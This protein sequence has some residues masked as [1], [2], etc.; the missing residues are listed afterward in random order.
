MIIKRSIKVNGIREV[1]NDY[2]A[3]IFDQWGVIHNGVV[4][5]PGVIDVFEKLKS[6][7]KKVIILTNSSKSERFNIV[8]LKMNFKIRQNYYYKLIS[9]ADFLV[10]KIYNGNNTSYKILEKFAFVISVQNDREVF[11]RKKNFVEK[12]ELADFV[13]LLSV[14]ENVNVKDNIEWI[15]IAIKRKLPLFCPSEDIKSLSS[16]SAGVFPGMLVITS[17]YKRLGGKVINMGKPNPAIYDYC[18]QYI[19]GIKKNRV[20]AI[21]DLIRTDIYGA[22]LHGFHSA[23]VKTGAN[24]DDIDLKS[25]MQNGYMNQYDC[26]NWVLDSLAW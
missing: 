24:K 1:V 5:Y 21:G 23:I 7:N 20:L 6:L 10:E 26:P 22:N 16:K 17:E 18:N 4:S 3:F 25:Y 19:S 9:S 15:E 13:V 12:I 8:R 14:D 11:Q 2:D